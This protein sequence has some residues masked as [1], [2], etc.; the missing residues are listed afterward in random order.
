MPYG[1]RPGFPRAGSRTLGARQPDR[2]SR[3]RQSP[4]Q[5][6]GCCSFY[7][8]LFCVTSTN[9]RSYPSGNTVVPR[10]RCQE[11]IAHR[12]E[13]VRRNQRIRARGDERLAGI[14][15]A[16]RFST[17]IFLSILPN[18]LAYLAIGTLVVLEF[19]FR[20]CVENN[21]DGFIAFCGLVG[22]I[23]TLFKLFR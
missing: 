12:R 3:T 11:R 17:W 14:R 2:R 16:G 10:T 13:I 5:R 22:S 23:A 20:K 7:L 18:L 6:I 1:P 21:K 15:D 19:I 8:T 4:V 9:V